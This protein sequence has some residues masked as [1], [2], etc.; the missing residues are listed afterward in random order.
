MSKD[1][2]LTNE[3][4]GRI[5][6]IASKKLGKYFS[7]FCIGVFVTFLGVSINEIYFQDNSVLN[8]IILFFGPFLF[9]KYVLYFFIIIHRLKSN[10][11]KLL[12]DKKNDK[13]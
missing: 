10:P 13:R 4:K 5:F 3:E 1:K 12:E 11:R 9:A 8:I 6:I 7:L 2:K